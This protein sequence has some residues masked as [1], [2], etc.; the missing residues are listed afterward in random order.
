MAAAGT[1]ERKQM[2]RG[3]GVYGSYVLCEMA[4]VARKK[5]MA[6]GDYRTTQFPPKMMG[7]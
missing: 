7:L 6:K 1:M 5:T 4:I 2:Q 3:R